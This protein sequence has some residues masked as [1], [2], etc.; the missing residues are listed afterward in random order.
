MT[1]G[2]CDGGIGVNN[3]ND[4]PLLVTPVVDDDDDD[5]MPDGAIPL[6]VRW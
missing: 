4:T 2:A 3:G 5:T 1:Y 6:D